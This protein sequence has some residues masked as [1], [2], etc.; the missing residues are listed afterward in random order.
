MTDQRLILEID[1]TNVVDAVKA[2]REA[3]DEIERGSRDGVL[4]LTASV[5]A[6]EYHLYDLI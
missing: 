4:P 2:A 6:A 1:A 3:L 5:T